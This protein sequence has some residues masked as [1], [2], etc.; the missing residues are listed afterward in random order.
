[1][2]EIHKELWHSTAKQQTNKQQPQNLQPNNLIKMGKKL[3]RTFPQRRH[4]N[5][6]HTL[7]NKQ[8]KTK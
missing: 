6:K 2:F 1:M 7:S 8:T 5:I 4:T 3:E